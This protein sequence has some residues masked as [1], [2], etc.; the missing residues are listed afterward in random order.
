MMGVWYLGWEWAAGQLPGLAAPPLEAQ[1]GV[2]AVACLCKIHA[3]C[4]SVLKSHPLCV[5]SAGLC[6]CPQWETMPHS[7]MA[8]G[9]RS[10]NKELRGPPEPSTLL[11]FLPTFAPSH[12]RLFKILIKIVHIYGVQHAVYLSTFIYIERNEVYS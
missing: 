2:S 4:F 11:S 9:M 12:D 5:V 6:V 1:G 3:C 8:P 7:P 10:C